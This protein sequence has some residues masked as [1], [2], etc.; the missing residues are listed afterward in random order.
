MRK[1]S[2][3]VI[4]FSSTKNLHIVQIV[5]KVYAFSVALLQINAE[6][7]K[8]PIK[9]QWLQDT[10]YDANAFIGCF[11]FE[12]SDGRVMCRRLQEALK[13]LCVF[14]VFIWL[15][16]MVL[17]N[18]PKECVNLFSAAHLQMCKY[19]HFVSMCNWMCKMSNGPDLYI[20]IDMHAQWH[21]Q[22]TDLVQSTTK[23]H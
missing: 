23:L 13:D 11:S 5:W 6:C 15:F 3:V 4:C 17:S 20:Y 21:K 14:D 10:E 7:F 18:E 12:M 2:T 8:D 9:I 19:F 1:K 22:L 16:Q